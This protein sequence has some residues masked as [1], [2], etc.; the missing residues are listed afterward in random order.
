MDVIYRPLTEAD[1]PAVLGILQAAELAEPADVFADLAEIQEEMA[2]PGVDLPR[3]SV[4]ATIDG[5]LVGYGA[6][7]SPPTEGRWVSHLTGG[8]HPDFRRHGIG[9][10]IVDR[11]IGQ[12][13][14]LR[15]LVDP[16]LTAE[17]KI[18]VSHGR[19]SAMALAAS[20]AFTVQRYFF[21]MRAELAVPPEIPTLPGLTV[22]PWSAADDEGA[23][24]AY[25][26]SSADHWGSVPM[27]VE[28]WR[29]SFAESSF[30]RPEVSRLALSDGRVVGFVLV[31]EFASETEARGFRTGYI[32]RVG[33]VRSVRGQG[34]ATALLAES[35]AALAAS[36]CS[37]A[38]LGVDADSPTGAGRLY[39]RLGFAVRHRNEVFGLEC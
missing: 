19:P 38:E 30:F 16:D 39:E 6:L 18:W 1:A 10:A 32:D 26:E 4:A 33:T 23:R 14:T 17:L 12:A 8:V 37:V 9:R 11:L 36:G 31:A 29:H 24:L 35:M 13:R 15:D 20:A 34:V 21:D 22:R 2:Q 5:R 28:R 25:N 27:D 7:I 3:G